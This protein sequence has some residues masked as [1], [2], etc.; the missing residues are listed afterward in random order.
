MDGQTD[1]QAGVAAEIASLA[2]VPAHPGPVQPDRWAQTDGRAGGPRGHQM[3]QPTCWQQLPAG[4][5][6]ALR[7]LAPDVRNPG[8]GWQVSQLGAVT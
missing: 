1:R 3:L 6:A 7:P 5:G 8:G 2:Q 4:R